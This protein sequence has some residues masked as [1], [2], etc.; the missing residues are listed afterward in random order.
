[1]LTRD[2]RYDPAAAEYPGLADLAAQ[3]VSLRE[4]WP[5]LPEPLL[6]HWSD[7]PLLTLDRGRPWVLAPADRDPAAVHGRSVV[8]RARVRDLAAVADL[9]VPVNRIAIAHELDPAGAVA[10]LLPVLAYGP[11]TCTDEVARAVVDPVPPPPALR[12]LGGA[13][14]RVIRHG[15]RAAETAVDLLLDPIVFGVVGP[16]GRRPAHGELSIFLPLTAWRW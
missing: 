3:A 2:V 5:S 10:G 16:D 6:W 8:P 11:R 9:G 13:V 12:R 4:Q 7:E 15:R 14:D 1:M